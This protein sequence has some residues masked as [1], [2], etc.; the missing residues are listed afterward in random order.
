MVGTGPEKRAFGKKPGPHGGQHLC[1]ESHSLE[2]GSG[3]ESRPGQQ[4][5]FTAA[6][7]AGAPS[8]TGELEFLQP[9][10]MFHSVPYSCSPEALLHSW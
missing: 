6:E 1:H 8:L 5:P 10:D 7:L 9:R 2:Q 3:C 4:V